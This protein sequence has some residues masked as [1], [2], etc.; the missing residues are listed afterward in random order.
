MGWV[1]WGGSAGEQGVRV[2]GV[3]MLGDKCLFWFPQMSEYL[4]W[5]GAG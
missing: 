1:G 4:G 2:H 5:S 3:N